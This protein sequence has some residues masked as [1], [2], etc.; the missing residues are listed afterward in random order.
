MKRQ[1]ELITYFKRIFK[2]LGFWQLFQLF[3]NWPLCSPSTAHTTKDQ[4]TC[5]HCTSVVIEKNPKWQMQGAGIPSAWKGWVLVER[6]ERAMVMLRWRILAT[7]PRPHGQ[8]QHLHRSVMM[9]LLCDFGCTEQSTSP[10]YYSFP[11]PKI[12]VKSR[13]NIRQTQTEGQSTDYLTLKI[14][15][16]VT[17]QE[18]WGNC[19]I[20]EG[21]K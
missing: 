4:K 6:M 19:P 10:L 11:K 5:Y 16:V 12:P 1:E 8:G 14:T 13:E 17:S 20:S 21:Y 7:A 9:S 15:K 18:R 3:S 2:V